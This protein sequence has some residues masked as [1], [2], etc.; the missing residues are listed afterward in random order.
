MQV[1]DAAD[2]MFN[3]GV[4]KKAKSWY[5]NTLPVNILT[6]KA[7]DKIPFAREL[8][9]IINRMSGRL[10]EKTEIL[11]SMTGALQKWQRH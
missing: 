10:R 8:N 2:V 11:G 3:E 1:L 5:L 6:E 4:G 9:T 7:K